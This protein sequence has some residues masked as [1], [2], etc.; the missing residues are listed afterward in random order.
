MK[1]IFMFSCFVAND[2]DLARWGAIV[3]PLLDPDIDV[4]LLEG[5]G[6]WQGPTRRHQCSG[7]RTGR[8][9]GGSSRNSPDTGNSNPA[10]ALVTERSVTKGATDEH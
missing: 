6:Q 5:L 9:A 8:P 7:G 1:D 3:A 2:E 4:A 10:N